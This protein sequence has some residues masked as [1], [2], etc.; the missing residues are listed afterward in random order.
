MN[1]ILTGCAGFVGSRV[2]R[3]L[4]K[5]DH[6]VYGIDNLNNAYDARIKDWRLTGL[7]NEQNFN[8]HKL[9][10]TNLND[11]KNLFSEITSKVSID[12]VI[13]LAARAGVRASIDDPGIYFNTNLIGTLNLLEQSKN[14]N[15]S[16][17]VQAST[18]SVYGDLK[19]PFSEEQITDF[20]LSPYAASKKSAENLCYTYHK[21]YGIDVTVLRYFTVYGP[22]GRPDMSPFRFIKW[23]FEDEDIILYG[24]GNQE[25]DFTYV[26]DIAL[27][28]VLGLKKLGYEIINLGNNDPVC[29]LELLNKIKETIGKDFNIIKKPFHPADVVSTCANIEKAKKILGW[30]PSIGLD[31]GIK[32]TVEWYQI[33]KEWAK[34]IDCN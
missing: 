31:E 11:L 34:N 4:L 8:F 13:N 27:G 18:S 9:D 17:F 32:R 21:L 12:A 24:D 33:N 26:D 16:K 7:I 1:I 6:V 10:I 5:E 29:I 14:N 30:S 20:P 25:R 3:L 19:I 2:A 15:V 22:A 23:I 28:T